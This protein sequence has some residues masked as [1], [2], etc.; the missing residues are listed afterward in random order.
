MK[1]A[2]PQSMT[3]VRWQPSSSTVAALVTEAG[4]II[5]YAILGQNGDN[6]GVAALI[7]LLIVP[8]LAVVI[9]VYWTTMVE[10]QGLAALGI[11]SRHW[12]LSLLLGLGLCLVVIAPLL[13]ATRI[14]ATP[15]RWLPMAAAGAFSL[16]EPL[17]IFGWLQLRFEKDFGVLPAILLAALC[18]ALYHIGY[19]PQQM[20]S[21]FYSAA[22]FAVVFRF[23]LNLLV[24]WPLL[25]ATTSA[26]ICIGS[27]VCFANWG[28]V[29]GWAMAFVVEV[30]VIAVMGMLQ[31]RR[32]L[33][34]AVAH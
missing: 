25:W 15:E 5:A 30:I 6:V 26:S 33:R 29:S 21:Q 8:I 20:T 1:T 19:L 34:A 14:T 22:A 12:L 31:R 27:N 11:T 23:T 2:D 7:G 28:M 16:F 10:R 4:M 32:E 18:F 9:P 3:L 13:F 17:F 24:T